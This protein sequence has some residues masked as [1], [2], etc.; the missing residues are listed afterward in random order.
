MKPIFEDTNEEKLSYARQAVL[1]EAPYFSSIV[2][3]FI[4][5][6]IEGIRT[7]LCTPKM[8]LGYDPAWIKVAS[9]KNIAADIVHEVNHFLRKHFE[10][11]GML[12][13][14]HLFNLAG[15]LAINPD[16]RNAGWE[17]AGKDTDCPAIFPA[18]YGFPEGLSTEEYYAL[19]LQ[20]KADGKLRPRKGSSDAGKGQSG[21]D[22]SQSDQQ[23]P[24]V[25]KSERQTEGGQGQGEDEDESGSGICAGHCG[26]IA[27]GPDDARLETSLDARE[28]RSEVEIKSITK[29][30]A[31]DIKAHVEKHG[32]GKLPRDI[33]DVAKALIEEPH[34]RWQSELAHVLHHTSGRIQSG[35]DDYSMS[36]PS[37]RSYTR[38]IVRPGLIEHQ[39]EVGIIRDSSGSMSTKQLNDCTREAYHIIQALGIDEVWYAD[40][41]AAVAMPWKR[42]GAQF[43]RDLKDVYGRGGTDFRPGIAAAQKL[44]PRPDLL[45]YCTDGDGYAPEQAPQGMAVVWALIMGGYSHGKAP[46]TWGYPIIVSDNPADRRRKPL[47]A[48]TDIEGD[49][50]D[51]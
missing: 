13:D 51:D 26:G 39:P 23:K 18:H 29:R 49:V 45:I 35:G 34:V 42:V 40:A 16:L 50:D 20:M 4:Y 5:V 38:G 25:G 22:P 33:A 15:D 28:G 19:L 6:P 8:V 31:A 10:R 41:D 7:M 14:P 2:H 9:I 48:G 43:F 24:S 12:E 1:F 17:L 47:P 37:K 46:A 36:R 44:F 3:G 30:A 21:S 32:R 11:G 27:G